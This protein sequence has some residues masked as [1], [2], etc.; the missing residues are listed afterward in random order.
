MAG[1]GLG[2]Q[3][4]I[5]VPDLDLVLMLTSGLYASPRQGNLA[6]DILYSFV[7]PSIIR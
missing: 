5:I 3:R 7:V 6:H 1:V 2:G 4:L